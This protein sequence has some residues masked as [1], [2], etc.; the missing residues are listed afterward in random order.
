MEI[1][2]K[3]L[4]EKN[5]EQLTDLFLRFWKHISSNVDVEYTPWTIDYT[6][7]DI[8]R[9]ITQ[10]GVLLG[11]F[12]KDKIIGTIGARYIP[13]TF[14]DS[15]LKCGIITFFALDPDVMPLAKEIKIKIFQ[16]II[17]EIKN[18]QTD[19]I[20][21]V[22][23][24]DISSKEEKIFKN[25]LQFVKM[26]KNVEPLT[27]LLGS[28]GVDIIKAKKE[29]NI[30]LAKLA[31]LMAKIETMQLPGGKIRDAT[32]DDYPKIVDLLNSYSKNLIIT[33]IWTVDSFKQFINACNR[34]NKIDYSDLKAEFPDAPTGF[35]LKVWERD[36]KII[37]SIAYRV[38]PIR[39]KNGDAP[40][41][42]WD[43]IAFS[44]DLEIEEKKAFLVNLYNE[45]YKKASTIT[46]FWPYYD[47]KTFKKTG[48][49]SSQ[50]N[51]PLYILPLTNKGEKLLELN[52]ISKFYLLYMEFLC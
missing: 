50:M 4:V 3:P 43:L 9:T 18:A 24:H 21:V 45:L 26:N 1:E 15:E 11:I 13:V 34:I 39:F 41:A 31:K 51:T 38:M 33:Q 10:N 12:S 48:F 14:Q 22:F 27:K 46:A 37:G 8:E 23:D 47:L 20:F 19:F 44:Q 17:E 25:D 29:L 2:I 5:Y 6:I 42:Y 49:M 32:A 40:L 36:N 7:Y 30:V 52:K 28:E 16:K 35:Y